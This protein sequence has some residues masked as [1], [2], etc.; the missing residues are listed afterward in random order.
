M[1]SVANCLV[2]SPVLMFGIIA[3]LFVQAE[4]ASGYQAEVEHQPSDL[5]RCHVQHSLHEVRSCSDV[6][7]SLQVAEEV[8]LDVG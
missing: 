8:D 6:P 3:N 1:D 2:Y 5:F 7:L 4:D